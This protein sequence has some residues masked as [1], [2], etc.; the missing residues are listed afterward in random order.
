MQKATEGEATKRLYVKVANRNR[1]SEEVL[2]EKLRDEL[3][4]VC[5]G[6]CLT[7]LA[8]KGITYETK[9]STP[10]PDSYSPMRMYFKGPIVEND[11]VLHM[12][13]KDAKVSECYCQLLTTTT[14]R[15]FAGSNVRNPKTSRAGAKV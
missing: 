1:L 11:E 4:H 10:A 13:K 2:F 9:M 8:V 7:D 5:H 6:M 15:E 14:M 12:K 3:K